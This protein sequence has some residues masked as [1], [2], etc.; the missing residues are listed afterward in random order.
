MSKYNKDVKKVRG[1]VYDPALEINDY[2]IKPVP[3]FHT[4]KECLA[5]IQNFE[6][7]AATIIDYKIVTDYEKLKEVILGSLNNKEHQ[8][9]T[10][11][12]DEIKSKLP[13]EYEPILKAVD[14]KKSVYIGEGDDSNNFEE[15][16]L[17]TLHYLFYHMRSGIY[18]RIEDNKVKQFIVFVNKDYINNWSK[19]LTFADDDG[20]LVD[21]QTYY[22]IKRQ[23]YRRENI[24]APERWWCNGH[25]LDNEISINLFG[26]HLV[27]SIVDMLYTVTQT[28][29][30]KDTSFFINKRDY[31]QI[32][33][34]LTEPYEFLFPKKT[35]IPK[36]Y[37]NKGFIPIHSY[38]SSEVFLDIMVPSTDDYDTLTGLIPLSDRPSDK[39]S[40][41]NYDRYKNIKWSEKKPIA[42]FRG[43]GT[44]G[45]DI[46]SNQRFKLAKI[47]F[48]YNNNSIE[49]KEGSILDAGVVT[50]NVRDKKISSSSPVT[51]VRYKKIGF[52]LSKFIPMS[53][54]MRAKMI[55][56][57]DGH[58]AAARY[59]FL[60]RMKVLILKV[61]SMRPETGEL[62]FFKMLQD[63]VDHVSVKSDMSDLL[64]KIQ[65]C[66][67]HD[68]EAKQIAKNAYKKYRTLLNKT[69]VLNYYAYCINSF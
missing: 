32:R 51:F 21:M 63:K 35:M 64:E 29:K 23:Y 22:K 66:I 1:E 58:A 13:E 9:Y 67:D 65:W 45:P 37:L 50:W 15:R 7:T 26:M 25:M 28:N 38:F 42:L 31:P 16:L 2:N 56:Y 36:E 39:Y 18:C 48:E 5:F 52:P 4:S 47:S 20:N 24:I 40:N 57:L 8:V 44:G 10:T 60:M 17:N 27:S 12:N 34:D 33:A 68:E 30:L 14:S 6:S 43:S 46:E 59:I 55:L 19:Y 54:Q 69:N 41:I 11:Y 62:W 3:K 61:E 53:E 49:P